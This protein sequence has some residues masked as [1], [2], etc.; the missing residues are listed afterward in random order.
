M[1]TTQTANQVLDR[2]FLDIRHRII[3]VAAT[4]DRIEKGEG[5]DSA[6]SDPRMVQLTEAIRLLIDGKPQRAERVQMIFSDSYD[7][8]WRTPQ[9]L[10][11]H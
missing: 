10:P 1:T 2:E 5:A 9:P 11:G 7:P 3:D 4:L 8:N 6:R